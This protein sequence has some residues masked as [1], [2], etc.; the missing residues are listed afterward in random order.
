[1]KQFRRSLAALALLAGTACAGDALLGAGP[2]V[3]N[4]AIFD[5]V[6]RAFDLHYS[7]FA[8][9]NVDWDHSRAKYRPLALA[10]GS[11]RALAS[12]IGSMMRELQDVHVVL[13]PTGD[14]NPMRYVSESEL[15]ATH[16]DPRRVISQYV[17][18][19]EATARNNITY[20]HLD[21][22][23]GYIAIPSFRGRDWAGEIDEALAALGADAVIVDV[24][25]NRGGDNG[26]A[27]EVA[28][29]F[30]DRERTYGYVRLRDGP[31]HDDFTDYIPERVRPA[32][33]RFRGTVIVL[34]NRQ[35]MSA[36]E[37]FALAMRSIPGVRVVGDTTAG[38]SGGPIVRELPNGWTF[39]LSEWIAY[40]AA[41]R[42]FEGSGLSPDIAV[43]TSSQDGD[44]DIILDT[45]HAIATADLARIH[46]TSG[47]GGR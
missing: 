4:A 36:A 18:D 3:D 31:S 34:T 26:L 7:Y 29:R 38:A 40:T 24:R 43:R 35:T 30:A 25:D 6:W 44:V 17:G 12:V 11:D 2:R 10:A 39:Q 32:G 5:E 46:N 28:G 27:V 41:R 13:T 33:R 21:D 23:V 8:I 37:D 45:A 9:R 15:R 1:M 16:F 14:I 19:A 20:G 47:G 42:P 22:R